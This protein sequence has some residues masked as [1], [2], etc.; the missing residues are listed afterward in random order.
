MK[1]N[2][3]EAVNRNFVNQSPLK[4]VLVVVVVIVRRPCRCIISMQL[5]F[6]LFACLSLSLSSPYFI[7]L[8]I[9]SGLGV[10]L[11]LFRIQ[12]SQVFMTGCVC[13]CVCL[14]LVRFVSITSFTGVR[15]EGSR[16]LWGRFYNIAFLFHYFHFAPACFRFGV[17]TPAVTLSAYTYTH[18]YSVSVGKALH[19]ARVRCGFQFST[20]CF[21]RTQR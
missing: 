3:P 2:H 7:C 9:R 8:F 18:T 17:P 4:C 10:S 6:C 12:F 1:Q 13:V 14:V 16:D 11:A 5:F 15:V 19:R 20:I 21:R